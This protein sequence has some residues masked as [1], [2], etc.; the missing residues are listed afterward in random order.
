MGPLAKGEEKGMQKTIVLLGTLDT[1]GIEFGYVKEKI[2]EQGCRVIMVDVG[3]LGEPSLETDITSEQ[4]AQAGGSSKEEIVCLEEG[5]ATE[6]MGKGAAKIVQ[7]LYRSGKLD[8]ILSLGGSMGTALATAA[9]RSL[10][11]GVPKVMVSTM[12]A[13]DTRPYLGTKDITMI[14]SVVDILGLNR[15]TRR[16]LAIAASAVAGMVSGDPGHIVSDK[17]L[18][19]L[20]TRGD[21]MPCVY[22]CKDILEQNGY[23]VVM[24]HAVGS[25]GRALEEWIGDG[26]IEGVFDL[27]LG[28]VTEHLF[29]G[30]LDAGP[31]RLE[32]AGR[33]GIPCL[34]TP[35]N[36]QWITFRGAQN[37]PQHLVGRKTWF[38][39]PAIAGVRASKDEM[40][41]VGKV[42]AEKLNKGNG[43]TAVLFPKRGFARAREGEELYN[44]EEDSALFEA[45]RSHLR[46]GIDFVEVDAHI[47]DRLFAETAANLL[48]E[49]I[50]RAS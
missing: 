34:A 50:H 7:E 30:I 25:G 28:E 48:N 10:P 41:L 33:Q 29:G 6:I 17:R 12:A 44:Q 18:I 11:F 26:L 16:I 42:I 43:P 9:M 13:S 35:G 46:P 49:L 5:Q 45:L 1:K 3:M 22:A 27:V 40:A 31:N 36:A 20:T 4:V 37:I 32:A 39:N 2:I 38:H 19:G 24:F 14:P 8:G 47:N 21:L 15:A 23:E